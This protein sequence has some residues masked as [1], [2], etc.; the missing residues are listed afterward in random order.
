MRTI[1]YKSY[2]F[3]DK[4]PAID[5]LRTLVQ[6]ESGGR[7]SSKSLTSI[8]VSGGP[9]AG[10]MRNWFFGK[11]RRPQNATMEAAGRAIGFQRQW[12]KMN[13]RGRGHR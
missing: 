5:A 12:V 2:V 4:D 6:D 10:T 9:K 11:T 1:I 8:E 13:G 3:R 7:L